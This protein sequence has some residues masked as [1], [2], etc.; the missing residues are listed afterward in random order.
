MYIG[1]MVMSIDRI[2]KTDSMGHGAKNSSTLEIY[3][4]QD[5]ASH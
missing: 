1:I 4:A 5:S 3:T 2:V